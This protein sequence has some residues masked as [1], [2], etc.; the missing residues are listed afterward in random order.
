MWELKIAPIQ[1]DPEKYAVAVPD[2]RKYSRRLRWRSPDRQIFRFYLAVV[3][4][5]RAR[6]R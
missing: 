3:H 2:V 6:L 1:D 4:H 5:K